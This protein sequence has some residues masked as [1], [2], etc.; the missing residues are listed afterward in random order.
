MGNNWFCYGS[1]H[2]PLPQE[3]LPLK[4]VFSTTVMGE[5]TFKVDCIKKQIT[6][7]GSSCQFFLL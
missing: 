1:G 3:D 7:V 6:L 5:L 4:R 2:F